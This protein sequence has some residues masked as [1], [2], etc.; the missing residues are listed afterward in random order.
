MKLFFIVLF[1]GIQIHTIAQFITIKNNQFVINNNSS[2]PIYFN[3]ANTPWFTWNDFDGAQSWQYFDYNTWKTEFENMKNHGLNSTRI[4]ISCDGDGQ[5][6][7]N[8][9][10]I[11]SNPSAEFWKNCD[12]LFSL[13]K[14]NGIYVMATMFSFDHTKSS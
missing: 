9:S 11:A 7:I 10:G 6:Y 5:P 1:T 8:S 14:Q 13:A 2:C 12:S 4:W 3:G